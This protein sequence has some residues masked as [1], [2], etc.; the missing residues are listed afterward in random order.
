MTKLI[1]ALTLLTASYSAGQSAPV[2]ILHDVT[3][4]DVR[5]GTEHAH[6]DI[7]I[8]GK[9]I[10]AIGPS[11]KKSAAGANVVHTGGYV[12]PGL[13]DM[14]VHL[15]GVLADGRWSRDTLLPQLLRYGIT[16]AR[17]MGSDVAV[18]KAWRAARDAGTLAS[19]YI[20]FGGPMLTVSD[21][22]SADSRTVRT[23]DDARKVVDELHAEGVDFIKIL[24]IPRAAYFPLA[25]YTRQ[26]RLNFVGHLP[27]GVTV[28]EAAEAGQ[29]SIEH[30]NW[31]VL[32]LDCSSDPKHFREDLVSALQSGEKGGYDRV[33]DDAASH[34]DQ[35][36]CA[37]AADAMRTH[38]TWL[39]PTLVAEET[40][41][42]LGEAAVDPDYLKLLPEHFSSDWE[43]EKLNASVSPEKRAWLKRQCDA[44][45][46]IAAFLHQHGVA[47]LPGSDSFDVG[48]LPGPTLHRELQLL[49]QIGFSP[50]EALRSATLDSATFIGKADTMGVVEA[51]KAADLVVLA[52]DPLHAIENT[53][54]IDV[55]LS[56]GEIVSGK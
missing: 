27:Y 32:A 33:L 6:L 31:S 41:A 42:H 10:A 36:H 5:T 25:E 16:G 30:V 9:K 8:E 49:V 12:I 55:V 35:T 44:D 51:G 50:A 40:A 21:A 47:M 18:L 19:P 4:I 28:Q 53:T 34:F 13:W 11:S 2:K 20:A 43:R 46:K 37:S 45:V 7:R 15:A 1:Y 48:N 29:K 54:K 26:Q 38:G 56:Q 3:V 24:H 39:V 23:A 17:D 52:A 22:K 14:H